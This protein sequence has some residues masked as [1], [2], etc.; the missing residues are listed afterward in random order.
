MSAPPTLAPLE[1]QIALQYDDYQTSFESLGKE[2]KYLNY[3]YTTDRHQSYEE[4]QERL[5][6]EV[7]E[8]A[9]LEA[10]DVVVDVGFG[11]GEQDF[12]A[13]ARYPFQQLWGI[14][15]SARQVEY[16]NARA[17]REGLDSRLT[18]YQA[19]AEA[20]TPLASASADKMLAIECAFY[21]DRPRF[22]QEAARVLKPGGLLVLADICLSRPLGFFERFSSEDLRR[23]GVW[24]ENI[25]A[26]ERYFFT[27]S[28]ENINR[29]ALPGC[30]MSVLQILRTVFSLGDRSQR[31]H[32]LKLA[33]SSQI[34]AFGLLLRLLRYDILVLERKS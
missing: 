3:G 14:N 15:I 28:V 34:V 11:S 12:F 27:R 9:C 10:Q 18:F 32:W 33:T 16:A 25:A 24:E 22:Y 20:M 6:Q 26:W 13:A 17:Q 19:P 21:F 30:Q 23:V 2:K 5:C 4:R 31:R 8:A 1:E 7:F 29:Y